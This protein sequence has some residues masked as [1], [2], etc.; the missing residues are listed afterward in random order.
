M[1]IKIILLIIKLNIAFINFVNIFL[2]RSK[3]SLIRVA[4]NVF[5]F[6]YCGLFLDPEFTKWTDCVPS[7]A[8]RPPQKR[9]RFASDGSVE[10][11][12]CPRS[13]APCRKFLI[14]FLILRLF[15]S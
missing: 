14:H 12:E 3:Y 13:T 10:S 9:F 7:C 15:I 8:A 4:N 1:L 2:P 11:E 6:I 5:Y